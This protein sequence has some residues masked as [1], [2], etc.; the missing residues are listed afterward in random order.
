[1]NRYDVLEKKL[2]K[3][4]ECI[5]KIEINSE[6]VKKYLVQY[7]KYV[8]DLILAT[9][10]KRI[11]NSNGALLGLIKGIS[12]YDELCSCDELWFCVQDAENY[13]MNECKVF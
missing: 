2:K 7:E 3:V 4:K 12:E 1:M 11:R 8:D 5:N 13:Y 10:E 9:Q 6:T